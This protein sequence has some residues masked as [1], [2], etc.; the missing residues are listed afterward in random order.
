MKLTG[1]ADVALRIL[2]FMAVQ[3][4]DK[5]TIDKLTIACSTPRPQVA[6]V[7]QILSKAGYIK[8]RR[9]RLGG[10]MLALSPSSI[11]VGK[12]VH[13]VEENFLL[14]PCFGCNENVGLS[15]DICPL[16][17]VCQFRL[18]LKNALDLFMSELG[19]VSLAN[20]IE[21]SESIRNCLNQQFSGKQS[22]P[23]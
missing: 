6:K 2:M 8:S 9:G 18:V 12:L 14:T 1:M 15:R 23:G 7:V 10:L 13:H 3:R 20:L 17:E 5:W 22:V 16:Q 11:N 19:S 21:D 4:S